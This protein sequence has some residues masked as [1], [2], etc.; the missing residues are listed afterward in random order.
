MNKIKL[1]KI[2]FNHVTPENIFKIFNN[3]VYFQDI[4]AC[5][6]PFTHEKKNKLLEN[7]Y[8]N[9]ILQILSCRLIVVLIDQL[10]PVISS[11]SG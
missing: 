8:E 10:F 2:F 4:V 7:V 5:N 6:E 3:S 11:G 9:I 1:I